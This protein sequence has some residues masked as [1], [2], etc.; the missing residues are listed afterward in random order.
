[1]VC[2]SGPFLHKT[3]EL[4][5]LE[6]YFAADLYM[7][8]VCTS[9]ALLFYYPNKQVIVMTGGICKFCSRRGGRVC[10]APDIEFIV[11]SCTQDS[12]RTYSHVLV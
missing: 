4:R 1:M 8:D 6:T 10:S 9:L 12:T 5:L 2:C 7:R 3:V 11:C